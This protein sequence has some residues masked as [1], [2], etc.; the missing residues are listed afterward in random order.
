MGILRCD[1]PD[2]ENFIHAKDHGDLSNFNVSIAVTDAFMRAVESDG[3]WELVHKTPPGTEVAAAARQRPDGAWIY[4]T[5]KARDLWQQ[6]TQSRASCSSTASTP[7][8]TSRIAS[9]SMR[10]TLAAS[11]HYP[12]TAAAASA[13]SI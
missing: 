3:D 5:V 6:I 7:T 8:T 12:P 1:H 11:S 2:I 9:G 4:R 13:A 10:L